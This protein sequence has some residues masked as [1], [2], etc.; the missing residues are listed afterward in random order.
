MSEISVTYFM[1]GPFIFWKKCSTY[2]NDTEEF[3]G[4]LKESL[5]ARNN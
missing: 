2:E 3:S 4:E 5:S 1:D